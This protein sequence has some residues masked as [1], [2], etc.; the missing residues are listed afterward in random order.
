MLQLE[1]L[2]WLEFKTRKQIVILLHS[3]LL[4]DLFVA[5]HMQMTD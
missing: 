5:E 4:T 1:I 2:E 3:Y